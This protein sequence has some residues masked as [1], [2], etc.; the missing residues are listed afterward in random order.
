MN[1][2]FIAALYH[3][4][5]ALLAAGSFLILLG[6]L[7]LPIQFIAPRDW[8]SSIGWRKPILFG[9][10]TGI[11]L[12]S[13]AWVVSV[14][15]KRSAEFAASILSVLAAAEVLII[16]VQ[17]WRGV[18][19]HFNNGSTVDRFLSYS[20][21]A[22]LIFITLS[23]FYLTYFALKA[24][25]TVPNDK[26]LLSLRLG[27]IYLSL[28]CVLGFA[29]A[30]YGIYMT[31]TGGNP[32]QIAPRGV[33]KFIHGMPLHALQILP[34]WAFVLQKL[35]PK[36]VDEKYSLWWLSHSIGLATIYAA[37]Q[38]VNGW[39]RFESNPAGIFIIGAMIFAALVSGYYSVRRFVR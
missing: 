24:S 26:W 5:R 20:I 4:N 6:V 23:I 21:D 34:I 35:K 31:Q 1:I 33:P 18:P 30:A 37:W 29:T 12:V 13:L 11:T 28:A 27:M 8:E 16:T 9:I 32:E 19:A 7:H 36:A 25:I 10:S 2:L 3:W 14:V 15:K 38:T 39:G 17:T 22:M